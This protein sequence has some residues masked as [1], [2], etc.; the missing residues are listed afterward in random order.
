MN[1]YLSKEWT[2]QV[3]QELLDQERDHPESLERGH[4]R[5]LG[6]AIEFLCGGN[7]GGR[8][9]AP[10]QPLGEAARRVVDRLGTPPTSEGESQ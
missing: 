5:A 10:W 8:P 6:N 3:L 4:G 7:I 2:V 9:P 1:P